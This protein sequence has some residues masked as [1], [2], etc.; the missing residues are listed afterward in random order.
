[1]EAKA[2]LINGLTD[3]IAKLREVDGINREVYAMT[4]IG[5]NLALISSVLIDI[6]DVMQKNSIE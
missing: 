3:E 6:R 1:M 5:L 2:D 4:V